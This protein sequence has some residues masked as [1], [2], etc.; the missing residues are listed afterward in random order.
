MTNVDYYFSSISPFTHL[1]DTGVGQIATDRL[2][3]L[4]RYFEGRT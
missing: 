4:G 2:N 1:A 3:N